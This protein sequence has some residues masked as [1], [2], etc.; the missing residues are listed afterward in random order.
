MSNIAVRVENLAKRYLIGKKLR[1]SNGHLPLSQLAKRPFAYL[2]ST[3]RQPTEDEIIWA[4]RDVSFEVT[5][6]EII[7]IIGRNGAGKS[8]LLKILSRITEPT[9]GRAL[10]KGRVG[11]LLEV[12]TGFHPELTGRENV[13]LSGAILGMKRAEIRR[14]F[15][16][17]VE[18]SGVSQFIDTPVKRYSS[19]MHVRLAFAVAAHLDTEILLVDEVLAVGDASFRKKCLGRMTESSN[20]GRTVLFVSHNMTAIATLCDRCLQFT[21]GSVKGIGEP[22]E[23]ISLYLRSSENGVSRG[24][25]IFP[26]E[27]D[28]PLVIESVRTLGADGKV[29]SELYRSEEVVI[30]IQGRVQVASEDYVVAIDIRTLD[31]TLLFRSHSFEHEQSYGILAK[32]NAFVLECTIPPNLLPANSYWLGLVT[33]VAGVEEVQNVNPALEFDIVQDKLLGERFIGS[34][35][36]LTPECQWRLC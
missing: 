24:I 36:I 32:K 25:N 28:L 17:I 21:H 23:I 6:G 8:T 11:S 20:E 19:G 3:L 7:G 10:V 33:A 27:I 5:K 16:E 26:P 35:G 29:S 1:N 22:N 30:Q 12:G 31:G 14:K 13:Y 4:L 18:F 9:S 15:D 2:T 34:R